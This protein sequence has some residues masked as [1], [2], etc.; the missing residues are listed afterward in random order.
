M[1]ESGLSAKVLEFDE[2]F[3]SQAK[4]MSIS[5]SG[6]CFVLPENI[7]TPG[8][9]NC[10]MGVQAWFE[11]ANQ[12]LARELRDLTGATMGVG[13]VV[14]LATGVGAPLAAVLGMSATAVTMMHIFIDANDNTLPSQLLGF[15]IWGNP[16]I[17]ENED[18]DTEGVWSADLAAQSNGW[19]LDW[20]TTLGN[21]PG[22]GKVAGIFNKTGMP[23]AAE[24]LLQNFQREINNVW[25]A[26]SGPI[27]LAPQ[28]HQ[29]TIDNNR[30]KDFVSWELNTTSQETNIDPFSFTQ[31]E[32]GYTPEAVG[33]ANLRVE[34]KGGDVFKG[35]KVFN[36]LE[37]EVE[38]I[39]V[40][41]A[42]WMGPDFTLENESPY[43]IDVNEEFA[44]EARVSNALNTDVQWSVSASENVIGGLS[45]LQLPD[46]ENVME[47]IANEPG[48]YT[49][50]AESIA[51]TG[52]RADNTPPR[53]DQVTLVVG[54]LI[55]SSPGC[56]ETGETYQLSA[57]IGGEQI[58]FSELEWNITGSG[59]IDSN[60]LYTA[61]GT[62]EV[63]IHFQV[64]DQPQLTDTISFSV[65]EMC[66]SFSLNS[67]EFSIS[68]GDCVFFTED[69]ERGHT[70][71]SFNW[72]K[73]PTASL[74]I[75][76][77][78]SDIMPPDDD[79]SVEQPG[80]ILVSV[81][82]TDLTPLDNL[83]SFTN[84][85]GEASNFEL[86]Q[87]LREINGVQV[88]TLSGYMDALHQYRIRQEKNEPPMYPYISRVHHL[89]H[90]HHILIGN[91][92]WWIVQMINYNI[93]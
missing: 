28:I 42:K 70:T 56:V 35:Q 62:G 29:F 60:G 26:D 24:F 25:E 88:R 27:D 58:D 46:L 33:T 67:S 18:D 79:W 1:N 16:A 64:I 82:R 89:S 65:N 74:S 75:M 53:F 7:S 34:T 47:V 80:W 90:Q 78:L 87:E 45:F 3:D 92:F 39:G 61:G 6:N 38:S 21:V 50:K 83:F 69:V 77:V 55:V 12:G 48:R 5:S 10:W 76:N 93:N 37:L 54:G 31:D 49:L 85:N 84:E 11:N 32:E 14:A 41:L 2:I 30:D 17:Y 43:Y 72:G 66:R 51:D 36:F 71:I 44:L 63:Q 4:L 57:R 91:Q 20:A 59:S 9:L 15:E 22:L 86:S 40:T 73:I 23:N 13:A 8:E 81:I 68:G 52:P 19:T